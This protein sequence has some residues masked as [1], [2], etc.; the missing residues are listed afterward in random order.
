M[1]KKRPEIVNGSTRHIATKCGR[2]FLTI[3]KID[4]KL[5]EVDMKMGKPGSC[6]NVWLQEMGYLLTLAI[7]EGWPLEKIIVRWDKKTCDGPQ[8]G[9]TCLVGITQK[10][11]EE[12]EETA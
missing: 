5:Y 7:Q 4:G 11:K 3:N 9:L 10:L 12:M 8:K 2:L 1:T 6:S